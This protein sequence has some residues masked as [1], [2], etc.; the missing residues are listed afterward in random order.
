M[1]YTTSYWQKERWSRRVADML[2]SYGLCWN[3]SLGTLDVK[4]RVG[5][6][7]Q[8]RKSIRYLPRSR[9]GGYGLFVFDR[10]PVAQLGARFH[11]M[12]EIRGESAACD[13]MNRFDNGGVKRCGP[14]RIAE[15]YLPHIR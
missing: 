8:P 10:G 5:V 15:P 3:P 1:G 9:C 2:T 4:W 6:E 14:T 13:C 12:E 7:S 11:G